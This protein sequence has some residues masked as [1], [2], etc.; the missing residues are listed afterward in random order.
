MVG[1]EIKTEKDHLWPPA[2]QVP[3]TRYAWYDLWMTSFLIHTVSM[4]D[5]GNPLLR[6]TNTNIVTFSNVNCMVYG[7]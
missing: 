3:V 7:L 2:F 1:R 5:V 4:P 6:Y